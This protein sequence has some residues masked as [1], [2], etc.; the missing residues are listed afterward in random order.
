MTANQLLQFLTQALFVTVFGVVIVKAVR[1][2]L[3]ATVDTALL[4]G[5]TSVVIAEQWISNVSGT[6]SGRLLEAVN[7]T[8]IMAM[9][10]LL[11]RLVEDFSSVR[12]WLMRAAEVGLALAALALFLG[13]APLPVG[14]TLLL[15]AYYF[16]LQL[17]AAMAFV[18]T[19]RQSAGVTCRR[20]QAAAAGSLF[21]GLTILTAGLAAA[22]PRPDELW[23]VLSSAFGLLSGLGYF[24]G[25][26]PPAWLRRTWQEPELRRFLVRAARLPRLPD[27]AAIVR[28]LEE[29]AAASLG[30]GEAAIGLWDE[31]RQRLTFQLRAGATFQHF[32]DQQAE[33]T[34]A[35]SYSIHQSMLEFPPDKLI[36][37]R[38][39][40]SQQPIYSPHAS[41]DDPENAE[42]YRASGTVAVL[43]APITAGDTRLGVLTVYAPRAPIFAED[44]LN[45]VELL[46]N[47][48][49]VILEARALIDDAGRVR[50]REEATRL[51][52][53][54]LSAAA[55]DLKTPL[56]TLIGQGQLLERRA[57][58]NPQAPA[59][60]DGIRRIVRES[61]RLRTLVTELLD[62]ARVEQGRLVGNRERVDLVEVA[63]EVCGRQT[64]GRHPCTV[65]AE[66]PVL[67]EFDPVRM[68]QLLENLVENA[69]KYSPDG[70]PITVT[71]RQERDE[72][73]ITV[74]DRGIGIPAAD[75][76]HL[77]DRF[78]RGANVDD[79][80]FA[81]MGL[82]LFICHGIVEQH[83]GQIAAVSN[84]GKGTVFR[85]SLPCHAGVLV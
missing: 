38:A 25:F 1:R 7:G 57:A 51:K 24:I 29:G 61:L 85:I 67:G 63:R 83:G 59:D 34:G 46:A 66:T 17:Y 11:L 42:L 60:I 82:G 49:A 5:V 32:I 53:D 14:V 13:P 69:V 73:Q 54:F 33:H 8:L 76:P 30:S 40:A 2:P 56:T 21:L 50:A 26:A 77:F 44:D 27:T 16:G 31:D 80:Q 20:M 19:A 64:S 81:G 4:F 62:A 84:L 22:F 65:V 75:L 35:D 72:A 48:A 23:R 18:R 6:E 15:V 10:Y 78:H 36:A 70:G 37:G 43:A 39:F 58:R 74:A 12:W 79:R 3:R 55:H 9:P 41:R 45:L 47:Q 68:M 52:D 71:V 28:E